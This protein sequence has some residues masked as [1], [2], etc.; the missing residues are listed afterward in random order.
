MELAMA[1][2]LHSTSFPMCDPK[3]PFKE[4]NHQLRLKRTVQWIPTT[5]SCTTEEKHRDAVA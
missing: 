2:A 4:G 3:K 5:A 1:S